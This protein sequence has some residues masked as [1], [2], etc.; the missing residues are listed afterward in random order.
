MSELSMLYTAL[1]GGGRY[2]GGRGVVG[3]GRDGCLTVLLA[4]VQLVVLQ[5]QL[6]HLKRN[7]HKHNSF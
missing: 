3:L 6:G 4:L 5:I 1:K 2:H 7:L